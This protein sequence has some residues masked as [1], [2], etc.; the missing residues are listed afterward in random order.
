MC[1][2]PVQ[3]CNQLPRHSSP[4][5]HAARDGARLGQS[6][7]SS[8]S[9]E[10][11]ILNLTRKYC[12]TDSKTDL[13]SLT[14]SRPDLF[15]TTG[16]YSQS[17]SRSGLPSML[18][19]Q[20][21]LADSQRNLAC[22]QIH[23]ADSHRDLASGGDKNVDSS[24]KDLH[25]MARSQGDLCG[26]SKS[27]TNTLPATHSK[28][29]SH[30]LDFPARSM[31]GSVSKSHTDLNSMGES[32]GNLHDG[33]SVTNLHAATSRSLRHLG[34]SSTLGSQSALGGLSGPCSLQDSKQFSSSP[35]LPVT[36][37]ET[38]FGPENKTVTRVYYR[39]GVATDFHHSSARAEEGDISHVE[40]HFDIPAENSFVKNQSGHVSLEQTN[41]SADV[42]GCFEFEL[43]RGTAGQSRSFNQF[44]KE[45]QHAS[46]VPGFSPHHP[47]SN[48]WETGPELA[49]ENIPESPEW[50]RDRKPPPYRRTR[51]ERYK[52][53]A[54][55]QF[56]FAQEV[57]AESRALDDWDKQM[58]SSTPYLPGLRMSGGGDST[59][60]RPRQFV[61]KSTGAAAKRTIRKC[62]SMYMSCK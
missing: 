26:T 54:G 57:Q 47:T 20:G 48:S 4:F 12:M 59:G 42:A 51:A 25:R 21:N 39:N 7:F 58:S 2:F 22:D 37:Y 61:S 11:V 14:N 34:L 23:L 36:R 19:S 60:P 29:H 5:S 27:Q 49:A 52:T 15:H 53:F 46:D 6:L 8:S 31:A 43:S 3:A 38:S 44:Q 62:S 35:N 33:N 9:L 24:R 18:N 50:A 45:Q 56:S 32:L 1:V 55:S 40:T 16:G 28:S 13:Y 17:Y 10:N 30:L 41:K